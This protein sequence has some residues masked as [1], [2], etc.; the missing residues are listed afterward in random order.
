MED[1][2]SY[3]TV[4]LVRH[5]ETD[6]NKLHLLQGNTD[7][8]LNNNGINQA[9]KTKEKLK[10]VNFSF[11]CSS[12]LSRAVK[13][14]EIILEEKN[15]Q[16]IISP[17]LRERN[18]GPLEGQHVDEL[19]KYTEGPS[20]PSLLQGMSKKE[21]LFQRW[22]KEIES[23]GEVFKRFKNFIKQQMSSFPKDSNILVTS[24]GGVLRSVIDELDFQ[25]QRK[26][27][28]SNCAFLILKISKKGFELVDKYGIEFS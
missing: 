28:V 12:D 25:P 3:Y 9:Y 5:G 6:W 26:M 27:R 15:I 24:H 22:H 7:I 4:Y 8:P 2:N 10:H 13:T 1:R 11:A 17:S 16:M 18:M 20:L 14:C 23:S 21:F 19:K